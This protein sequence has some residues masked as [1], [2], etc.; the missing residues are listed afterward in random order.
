M[1]VIITTATTTTTTPHIGHI[2]ELPSGP[3]EGD[4]EAYEAIDNREGA[5]TGHR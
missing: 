1:A 3:I 4:I 5:G 2:I